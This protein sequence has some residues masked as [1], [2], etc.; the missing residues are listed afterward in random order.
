MYDETQPLMAVF[1][2]YWENNIWDQ[3]ISLFKLDS[4]NLSSIQE[5]N[6]Q[7]LNTTYKKIKLT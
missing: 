3:H 6:S 1:D 7:I 4:N 2:F 5:Q